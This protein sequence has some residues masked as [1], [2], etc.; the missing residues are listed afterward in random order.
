MPFFFSRITPGHRAGLFA[1]AVA[2][3][4]LLSGCMQPGPGPSGPAPRAGLASERVALNGDAEVIPAAVRQPD[5]TPRPTPA[6]VRQTLPEP[7]CEYDRIRDISG[8]GH[9]IALYLILPPRTGLGFNDVSG[10]YTILHRDS[11][12]SPWAVPTTSDMYTRGAF[13][14]SSMQQSILEETEHLIGTRETDDL[15]DRHLVDAIVHIGGEIGDITCTE[16]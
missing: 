10:I 12:R 14:I 8:S 15:L 16:R 1:A 7:T 9:R 6:T 4:S 11:V 3:V 5:Y 2:G 13:S